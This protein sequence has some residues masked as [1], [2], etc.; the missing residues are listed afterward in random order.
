MNWYKILKISQIRG[1][2]WITD[3]GQVMVTN[4]EIYISRFLTAW[5]PDH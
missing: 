3:S 5:L 4:H 1:E 2:Y